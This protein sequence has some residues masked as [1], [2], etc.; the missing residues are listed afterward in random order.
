MAGQRPNEQDVGVWDWL[1]LRQN[2]VHFARPIPAM[3][4]SACSCQTLEGWAHLR[5]CAWSGALNGPLV[6]LSMAAI[7]DQCIHPGGRC[8]C[9]HQVALC[10]G[11]CASASDVIHSC[12]DG[13][14]VCVSGEDVS[15]RGLRATQGSEHIHEHAA[16]RAT[17]SYCIASTRHAF[18]GGMAGAQLPGIRCN[19]RHPQS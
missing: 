10:Q 5:E 2:I 1:L 7:L 9:C 15:T 13:Q 12:R 3:L 17:G 19:N 11:G 14:P 8:R 18:M 6:S 4:P 16:S